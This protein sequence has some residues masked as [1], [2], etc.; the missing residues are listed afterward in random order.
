M[1]WFCCSVKCCALLFYVKRRLPWN[2]LNY[3]SDKLYLFETVS[4][5]MSIITTHHLLQ[6]EHFLLLFLF[7]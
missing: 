1:Y 5:L 6:Q 3:E 4:H 2:L 7:F